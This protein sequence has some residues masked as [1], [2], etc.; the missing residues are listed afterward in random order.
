MPEELTLPGNPEK[1]KKKKRKKQ[2]RLF[3][4]TD[5]Y[6]LQQS[7]V[8]HAFL[9]EHI[10]DFTAFDPLFDATYA[11]NWLA[12]IEDGEGITNDET[13]MDESQGIAEDLKKAV[14]KLIACVADVEYYAN[15][16]FENDKE[17]LYEFAFQK[18][19]RPEQYNLNFIINCMVI[20]MIAEDDYEVELQAAGMPPTLPDDLGSRIEDAAGHEVNHEKFKRTR[21]KRTR[22]RIKAYN[23][24]YKTAEAVYN[25]AQ[26]MYREN[27]TVSNLFSTAIFFTPGK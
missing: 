23:E 7:R 9:L 21:I 1:D 13:T 3:K 25:A 12:A 20:R 4:C 26:V 18:V 24:I 8:K 17:V 2:E 27:P 11:A 10:A 16:A 14:E 5:A 19:Q 15:K 22:L 6:L